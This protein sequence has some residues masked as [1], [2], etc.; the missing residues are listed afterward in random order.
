MNLGKALRRVLA[1]AGKDDLVV[2][3]PRNWEAD[4]RQRIGFQNDRL[5]MCIQVD[6][7]NELPYRAV[8]ANALSKVI[9]PAPVSAPVSIEAGS[10]YGALR[11]TAGLA[12]KEVLSTAGSDCPKFPEP[13]YGAWRYCGD[14]RAVMA[15]TPFCGPS[16]MGSLAG[17]RFLPDRVEATDTAVFAQA[18]VETGFDGI[19]PAEVFE[20]WLPG[21]VAAAM[22]GGRFFARVDDE[23]RWATLLHG[24]KWPASSVIP[25]VHPHSSMSVDTERLVQAAQQVKKL[26]AVQG[27]RVRMTEDGVQLSVAGEPAPL[28]IDLPGEPPA[29]P[30]GLWVSTQLLVKMSKLLK[31]PRTAVSIGPE[32]TPLRFDSGPLVL[33]LWPL[34]V[35]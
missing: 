22:E 3:E 27:V 12:V 30:G 13:A 29:E 14:W 24:G 2:F 16:W 8:P 20:H 21:D 18:R 31:T 7:D 11:V 23:V 10:G 9:V 4:R 6:A 25:D 1:L 5:G 28:V 19:V 32:G 33:C 17:L 35:S 34:L 26:G 15:I